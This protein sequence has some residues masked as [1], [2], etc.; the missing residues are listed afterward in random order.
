M[1]HANERKAVIY[2]GPRD[3]RWLQVSFLA[4]FVV[5]ATNSPAFSRHWTQYAAGFAAC[6]GV[7]LLFLAA[8]GV[9]L[10]P[11]SGVITTL[12]LLLLVDSPSVWPY[13]AV[14]AVSILSKHL[15]RVDGR[16]LFN[17]LNFGL[18]VGLLFL[19]SEVTV[20]PGRWGGSLSGMAAV[21]ALGALT[22]Y[23]AKRLDLALGWL[24]AFA[25]GACLRAALAHKPAAALLAPVTGASFQLFTFFMI[26]DPMTTPQTRPGRL[27]FAGLLGALDAVLRSREVV[28]APFF[29][30]FVL[31][32]F[33]PQF[34]AAFPPE[35]A[36]R[37]WD[38]RRA[39]P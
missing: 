12:G 31:S 16:H 4:S 32:A 17:P 2:P 23:R 22:V 20:Q 34:R 3:P 21:A 8:K 7:E 27:T 33:L 39:R 37:V 18:V 29:A 14:G 13:A 24:T 35:A 5:Y 15:L 30:L 28:N 19:S 38:P 10:V 25:L 1:A 9:R 26:T 6:M 11:L 36:E